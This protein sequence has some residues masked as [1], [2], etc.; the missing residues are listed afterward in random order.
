MELN[1]FNSKQTESIGTAIRL[2]KVVDHITCQIAGSD[3]INICEICLEFMQK[4]A[5]ANIAKIA[6]NSSRKY[7]SID[8]F[9]KL[10]NDAKPI[11]NF[12]AYCKNEKYYYK[13]ISTDNP[14]NPTPPT[15][16]YYE[17]EL[18]DCSEKDKNTEEY[19]KKKGYISI[20]MCL[21]NYY[22]D[23]TTIVEFIKKLYPVLNIDYGHA[24]NWEKDHHINPI[25]E[26]LME[27]ILGIT[28]KE[29]YSFDVEKL[30]ELNSGH[31]PKIFKFNILNDSQR[32]SLNIES[33]IKI[34][35]DLQ[36]YME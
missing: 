7:V 19:K 27:N 12:R 14:Y 15:N 13:P 10:I 35:D 23:D 30:Y 17:N 34:T 32:K 28:S 9:Y 25:G 26:Y 31:V 22:I 36:L 16:I 18:L 4:Y 6:K 20:I 2:Y 11:F 1:D 33:T 24:F 21:K 29:I 3:L 5:G 8:N